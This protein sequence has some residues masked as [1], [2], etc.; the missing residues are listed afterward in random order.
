MWLVV[1]TVVTAIAF[2]RPLTFLLEFELQGRPGR[3][4]VIALI[5]ALIN[6]YREPIVQA[7][8][9]PITLMT[10]GLVGFLI[11]AALLLLVAV[12]ADAVN[13]KFTIGGFPPELVRHG[14]ARCSA[15]S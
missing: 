3:P 9:F 13:I 15:R 8:S 2:S 6:G 7:L 14:R 5:S 10:M 4:L 11:N 12:L 1:G